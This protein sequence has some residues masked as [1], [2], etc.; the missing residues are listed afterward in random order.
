[1]AFRRADCRRDRTDPDRERD[2]DRS[3]AEHIHPT[4]CH[5][6]NRTSTRQAELNEIGVLPV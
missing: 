6:N 3:G 2:E 4:G 5:C 1:M